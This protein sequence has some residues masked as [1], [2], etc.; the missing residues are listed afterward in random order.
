MEACRETCW[1]SV[2]RISHSIR[3]LNVLPN[4]FGREIGVLIEMFRKFLL[5]FGQQ[6]FLARI[7]QSKQLVGAALPILFKPMIDGFFIN[8]QGLGDFGDRPTA[9][10]EN[11][12][13]ETISEELVS[14]FAVSRFEDGDLLGGQS[15]VGHGSLRGTTGKT[16]M[17]SENSS[18]RKS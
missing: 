17:L 11:H 3:L 13:V 7:I 15:E 9:V 14:L 1:R 16:I 5:F 10:E 2:P 18:K 6:R 12:H 4:L 8:K